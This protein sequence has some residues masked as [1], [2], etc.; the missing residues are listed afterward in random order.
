MLVWRTHW[1]GV[2]DSQGYKTFGGVIQEA[3]K[4]AECPSA[5]DGRGSIQGQWHLKRAESPL[6]ETVRTALQV[7]VPV[8]ARS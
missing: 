3:L 4:E 8:G 6:R 5:G 2:G 1:A 7:E